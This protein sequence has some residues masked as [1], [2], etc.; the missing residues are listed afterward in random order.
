MTDEQPG[1]LQL[2]AEEYH[3]DKMCPEPSL[4]STMAKTLINE[5]PLDAWCDSARLNPNYEAPEDGDFDVGHAAHKLVLG[6]GSPFECIPSD[7]LAS[8]GAASTKVAK[9]WIADARDRGV[10][11]LTAKN[12]DAVHSYAEAVDAALKLQGITFDSARSELAAYAKIDDVWCRMQADNAPVGSPF[13]FDLKTTAGSVNPNELARVVANMGYAI[14]AQH[15]QRVWKEATGEDRRMRF[16]FVSK[17][18]G[19]KKKNRLPQVGIIELHNDGTLRPA[20]DYEPDESF[21]GDWY[22][23]AEQKLARARR[24]FRQCLDTGVWPGYP[25]RVALVGAPV[26]YR[27]ESA[28]MEIDAV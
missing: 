8:N 3:A 24:T 18:K 23:D 4:S 20:S 12:Y 26:W 1:V 27:R 15:Y 21:T 14:S 9:E 13:I 19:E 5:T 10:T 7:L 2:S 25:A 11:P 28:M 22:A 6:A 16:V 17:P